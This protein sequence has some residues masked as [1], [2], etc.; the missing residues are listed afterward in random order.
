[1]N[2]KFWHLPINYLLIDDILDVCFFDKFGCY[3]AVLA[4]LDTSKTPSRIEPYVIAAA[5]YAIFNW[6]KNC[7]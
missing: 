2:L 4:F 5:N 3:A 1:M 6:R 7:T